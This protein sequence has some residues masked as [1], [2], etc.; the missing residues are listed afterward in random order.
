MAGAVKEGGATRTKGFAPV[1]LARRVCT[2]LAA[3]V[4]AAE[5]LAILSVAIRQRPVEAVVRQRPV[6]QDD[7]DSVCAGFLKGF[8]HL[9]VG[10]VGGLDDQRQGIPGNGFANQIDLACRRVVFAPGRLF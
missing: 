7:G 6:D 2:G 3:V 10:R 5:S 4:E 9:D 8:G 1:G